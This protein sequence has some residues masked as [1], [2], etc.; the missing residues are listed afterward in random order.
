MVLAGS[1]V[2]DTYPGARQINPSTISSAL[3]TSLTNEGIDP[4]VWGLDSVPTPAALSLV[5]ETQY[6]ISGETNYGEYDPT[7]PNIVFQ[8]NASAAPAGSLVLSPDLVD[9]NV[10]GFGGFGDLV[11][12]DGADNSQVTGAGNFVKPAVP[13][14]GDIT[15]MANPASPSLSL[16]HI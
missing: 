16:I 6:L 14:Y 4:R 5:F 2:G 11:I 1:L 13:V 7:P 8:S 15:V 9:S 10:T 3:Q 12:N